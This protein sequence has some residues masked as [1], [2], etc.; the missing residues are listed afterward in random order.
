MRQLES[1]VRHTRR[2]IRVL[3]V[4]GGSLAVASAGVGLLLFYL[5]RPRPDVTLTFSEFGAYVAALGL[6]HLGLYAGLFWQVGRLSRRPR[7]LPAA[8]PV[9]RSA[10]PAETP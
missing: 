1:A 7:P 2:N 6:L 4:V 8:V 3:L 9:E 5:G 10:E